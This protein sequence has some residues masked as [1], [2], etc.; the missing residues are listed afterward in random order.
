[1]PVENRETAV[2][3]EDARS[4]PVLEDRDEFE[5]KP[6]MSEAEFRKWFNILWNRLWSDAPRE[7]TVGEMWTH[8]VSKGFPKDA[9]YDECR[10]RG[11]IIGGVR[12]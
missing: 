4:V 10:R 11:I 7:E 9:F 6:K 8:L 3:V 1:M 2:G 12:A 5:S